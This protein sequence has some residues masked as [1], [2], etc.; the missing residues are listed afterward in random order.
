MLLVFCYCSN[1]KNDR[2]L[3]QNIKPSFSKDSSTLTTTSKEAPVYKVKVIRTIPHDTLSFT[4][5]LFFHNGFLYESTGQYEKSSLRKINPINGE[6]I[7][8]IS[9]EPEYFGEGI[10]LHKGKIYM[11]TWQNNTCLVFDLSTFKK[12]REIQYAGEGWGIT[13]YDSFTL[14]QSDGTNILKV[15]DPTNFTIL[16]T[17]P[18]FYE[19]SP[20][21][22][23]NELENIEDDIWANIWMKDTIVVIDKKTGKVKY[24]VDVS[25]LRKYLSESAN[26]DVINGIAYDTKSKRI[27]LTGK[28]WPYIF[29]VEIVYN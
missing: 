16:N 15:V 13:N 18:V 28:D 27:Y 11:L 12:E 29:E 14:V 6:V 23:L 3:Q 24:F 8:K 2:Y 22:N 9:I 7:Q 20:I 5:G 19:T 25:S 10:A 21:S 17:I 4:Q 26:V 1:N